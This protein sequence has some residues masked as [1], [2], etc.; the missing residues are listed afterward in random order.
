M[1]LTLCMERWEQY[2]IWTQ[3]ADKWERI[4]WFRDLDVASAVMHNRHTGVRLVHVIYEDGKAVQR[5]IIAEIA[6]GATR[7]RS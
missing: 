4:A 2:E 3:A 7:D 1:H 6:A 5:D